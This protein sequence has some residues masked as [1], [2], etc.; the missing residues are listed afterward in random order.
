ME[1]SRNTGGNYASISIRKA[2]AQNVVSNTYE[3]EKAQKPTLGFEA[4]RAVS[5][6]VRDIKERL[7]AGGKDTK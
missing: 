3:H 2:R 4:L 6:I 7:R 5:R 1:K